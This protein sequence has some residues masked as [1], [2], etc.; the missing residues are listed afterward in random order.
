MKKLVAFVVIGGALVAGLPSPASAAPGTITLQ[1]TTFFGPAAT[2]AQQV[3]GVEV[4]ST[5][6]V[7]LPTSCTPGGSCTACVNDIRLLGAPSTIWNL[8]FTSTVE[9]TVTGYAG[10]YFIFQRF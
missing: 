1:C 4:S 9:Q 7:T 6:A 5:P 3:F 8:S 10:P 2:R